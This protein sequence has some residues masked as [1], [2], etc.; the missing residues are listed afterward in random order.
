MKTLAGAIELPSHLLVTGSVLGERVA[1]TAGDYSFELAM[2]QFTQSR[3]LAQ[4][5]GLP[6]GLHLPNVD[7]GFVANEITESRPLQDC[8]VRVYSVG[9]S[10]TFDHESFSAHDAASELGRAFDAW[11]EPV[12]EWL[13]LWSGQGISMDESPSRRSRGY[14]TMEPSGPTQTGWG[15]TGA[16]FIHHEAALAPADIA[17]ACRRGTAGQPPPEPWRFYLRAS[18]TADARRALIDAATAVEVCLATAI[19]TRLSPIAN[20]ARERVILNCN[21]LVGMLRL[22]ESLDVETDSRVARVA[23]RLAGPRNDAA[24]AGRAPS[25]GEL[26]NA[27]AEVH[28]VLTKYGPITP[29]A[30][31]PRRP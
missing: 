19:A 26:R 29:P 16:V 20:H 5:S 24:H 4:P 15:L 17:E 9:F 18:R 7:W 8:A 28:A 10:A 6:A 21:G 12:A 30:L 13:A 31:S 22:V 3:I 2:P 23:H 14:A 25:S 27:L 1:G 11:F